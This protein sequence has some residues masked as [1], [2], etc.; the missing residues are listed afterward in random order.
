MTALAGIN[1][2]LA[3]DIKTRAAGI[4]AMIGI[5]V[6]GN[7]ESLQRTSGKSGWE[8]LTW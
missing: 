3:T 1:R 2:E 7:N 4:S 8:G 5:H 6:C